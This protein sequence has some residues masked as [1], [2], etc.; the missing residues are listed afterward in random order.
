[1][2]CHSE[3]GSQKR[4]ARASPSRFIMLTEQSRGH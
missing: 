2:F 3:S 1:M 4:S